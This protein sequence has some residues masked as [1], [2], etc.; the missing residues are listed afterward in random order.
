MTESFR[1]W[2]SIQDRRDTAQSPAFIRWKNYIC[3]T[4]GASVSRWRWDHEILNRLK[5][6]S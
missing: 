5:I 6:K 3:F 4:A 2:R 1:Y